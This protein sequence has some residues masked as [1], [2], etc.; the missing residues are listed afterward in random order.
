[1]PKEINLSNPK[2]D[3]LI[4]KIEEG[5]IKIP[6]L[7]RPF[8]W[9]TEQ[10]MRLLES[11][12][13]DY[14]IGSILLWE[15]NERLPA[16]RNVAGFKI[17]DKPPTYPVNYVLDGQQRLSSLYGVF[18][19]DRTVDDSA[20]GYEIDSQIF[21]ISFDL[22]DKKFLEAK[23]KQSGR[24]YID[25]K[26]LL[27]A[28]KFNKATK[29]FSS[30]ELTVASQL[31]SAFSNYEV[32]IVTT[33]KRELAE[34]GMIFERI[35]NS[36]TK[37]DLFDLMVAWTWTREFHLKEEFDKIFIVLSEK[38][39]GGMDRKIILQCI[40]AIM[41]ESSSTK[42]I[43]KL[44]PG[45]IRN[46]I[47]ALR[48]S[49]EKTVDYFSTELSIKS[50]DLLPHSH[51]IVSL[52]YFFS[53]INTPT[54]TQNKAIKEWF[55]KTSFSDRYS[56]STDDHINEDIIAF[57]K[58]IEG[59]QAVFKKYNYTISKEQ[60][61]ESRF[62][63][64]NP[65]ARSFIVLLA[66][67]K[68]RDL[69]NGSFVDIGE[70]LSAFNKRE[71]HH[72]FPKKFLE[73]QGIKEDKINSISNFC[74]LP[75]ASNKI[76]KDKAPDDYFNNTVFKNNDYKK[77]FKSNL[78]PFKKELYDSNDYSNFLAERAALIISFLDSQL[79]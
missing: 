20:D 26:F 74:M 25:M 72:I 78:L 9:K 79:I 41:K 50:K 28:V 49:L 53:K 64:A 40:S 24:R 32:P 14:P 8:V 69:V 4:F 76:I 16:A 55:W 15:T 35:N 48:T 62:R 34:V 68:P 75:S 13:N 5:E 52:C 10:V 63:K 73:Q 43:L 51:Q 21:N 60:L 46:N 54:E 17:P 3:K 37:L 30:D 38:N 56:Y 61:I 66:Q 19:Q 18:C 1:M 65:Y 58:L 67:N 29:D 33:K 22:A 77:I 11:I 31:Q 7:Q 71:Y 42:A 70:A 57:K 45:E 23:E 2:I 47:D 59:D 27:N 39:F 36:G 44:D 12:Y 6:P